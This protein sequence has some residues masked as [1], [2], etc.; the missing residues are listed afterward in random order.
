MARK[1]T[2][3]NANAPE[4]T[5]IK[6]LVPVFPRVSVY[7]GSGTWTFNGLENQGVFPSPFQTGWSNGW[8]AEQTRYQMLNHP[9]VSQAVNNLKDAIL[10]S[11][12]RWVPNAPPSHKD[13]DKKREVADF[14]TYLENNCP[15]Y[16]AK[17]RQL[18]DCTVE[19][20]KIAAKIG[21]EEDYGTYSGKIVLDDLQIIPNGLFNYYRDEA[22]N[23]T[24]IRVYSQVPIQT[25]WPREKFLHF[26]WNPINNNPWG[27]IVL[28]AAYEPYYRDVQCDNE[29]MAYLATFGRPS[30]FVFAPDIPN[31]GSAGVVQSDIPLY[32]IDGTPV[33]ETDPTTGVQTQRKGTIVDSNA[34]KFSDYQSGSVF[35]LDGGSK[36][37][38]AEA[39]S[40]GADM[41]RF[42]RESNGRL[43]TA[44]IIGT[45]QM[46]DSE[47]NVSTKNAEVGEGV[48]GLRITQGQIMVERAE[49]QDVAYPFIE[50]NYGTKI[51]R[52]HL[53]IRD[54]GSRRNT[55]MTQQANALANYV[56]SGAFTED[57][58]WYLCLENGWG[59]P[60]PGVDRVIDT[61]ARDF[62]GS[63]GGGQKTD[64]GGG[65]NVKPAGQ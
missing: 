12:A 32:Y 45:H 60:Y 11:P 36:V 13:F 27:T 18:L 19:G 58:W 23:T 5:D 56:N 43:I 29:E 4:V 46:T 25:L 28:S 49:E 20:S 64:T 1:P 26:S 65:N 8:V 40:G 42:M 17:M 21:R 24:H 48:A 2:P 57:Q 9:K 22:G 55:R 54:R 35:S 50:M 61:S 53:P 62:S 41:F 10:G 3:K 34:Y 52:E 63:A 51:A 31:L 44:A 30:I 59:M 39:R 47:R 38:I 16:H 14:C 6:K 15:G 7:G 33:M 37:Q